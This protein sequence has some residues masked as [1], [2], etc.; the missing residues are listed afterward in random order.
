MDPKFR[1]QTFFTDEVVEIPLKDNFFAFQVK[2]INSQLTLNEIE[3][4][5]GKTYLT[6][7]AL[8]SYR[9]NTSYILTQID[10]NLF[11]TILQNY[12][13]GTLEKI[14]KMN[15]LYQQDES[16]QLID[17]TESKELCE[18]KGTQ[19]PIQVPTIKI[20]SRETVLST[21]INHQNN[22]YL[23]QKD[24]IKEEEDTFT[25]RQQLKQSNNIYLNEL[26]DQ[27]DFKNQLSSIQQSKQI[28]SHEIN[29]VRCEPNLNLQ[30]SQQLEKSLNNIQNTNLPLAQQY[31][32]KNK[33]NLNKA[34]R[35]YN[36]KNKA[37]LSAN[38]SQNLKQLNLGNLESKKIET[39]FKSIYS[40]PTKKQV[41]DIL[42]KFKLFNKKQYLK[43]KGLDPQILTFK[44]SDEFL[45]QFTNKGQNILCE[46]NMNHFEE[47]MA[48]QL[49]EDFQINQ[50]KLFL[51]KCSR[52]ENLSEID[53]RIYSSLI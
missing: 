32:K 10:Q 12:Y 3:D 1:S 35:E 52:R 42:F 31:V 47:Q 34:Q 40:Q 21:L 50:I 45:Q 13:Q 17:L 14:L 39:K 11:I 25:N 53:Q 20:N 51:Q 33:Q 5:Q 18:T 37:N 49:S 6:F 43:Q 48:V 27:P 15:K 24:E 8:R 28:N 29:T 26:S 44:C 4:Q 7:V 41:E 16:N 36:Q 46:S 9:N 19:S 38:I 30:N 23:S 22:F 2:D